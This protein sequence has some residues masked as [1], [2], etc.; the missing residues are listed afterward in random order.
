MLASQYL[1]AYLGL[2]IPVIGVGFL[3]DAIDLYSAFVVFAVVIGVLAL[4]GYIARQR[5]RLLHFLPAD[6]RKE[7]APVQLI[8]DNRR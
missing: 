5:A 4:A 1:V 3:V 2:G 7:P 8:Q 6:H